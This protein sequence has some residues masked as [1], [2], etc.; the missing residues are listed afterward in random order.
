MFLSLTL[1]E[2]SSIIKI[3]RV[4]YGAPRC[5]IKVDERDISSHHTD[6]IITTDGRNLIA[7]KKPAN[8]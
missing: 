4:F 5:I 1:F 6:H 2:C 8:R 3:Y 7:S